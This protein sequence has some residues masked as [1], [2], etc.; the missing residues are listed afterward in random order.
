MAED[1][2]ELNVCCRREELLFTILPAT[3]GPVH[4]R[5]G[6]AG[7]VLKLR[8]HKLPRRLYHNMNPPTLTNSIALTFT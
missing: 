5:L 8:K 4:G 6:F 7:I 2:E 3:V 1:L